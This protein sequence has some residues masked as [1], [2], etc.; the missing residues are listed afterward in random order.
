[1]IQVTWARTKTD[2]LYDQRSDL[3]LRI[4][5]PSAEWNVRGS[6]SVGCGI[7]LAMILELAK[8]AEK[9]WRRLD[10]HSRCRN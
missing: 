9:S 3:T 5:L 1:M 7:S 8:A 6:A 2:R 4:V 10:G